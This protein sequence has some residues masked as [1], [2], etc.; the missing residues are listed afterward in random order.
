MSLGLVGAVL[1][2]QG[3]LQLVGCG[4]AGTIVDRLGGRLTLSVALTVQ[5]VA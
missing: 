2:P 4:I 5:A 3:L 1:A